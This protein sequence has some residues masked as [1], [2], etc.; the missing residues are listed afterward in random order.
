MKQPLVLRKFDIPLQSA[1][2][3]Y[4]NIEGRRGGII[5]FLLTVLN[6]NPVTSF[7]CYHNRIEFKRTSLSGEQLIIIPLTAVTAV[8]SGFTKPIGFLFAGIVFTYCQL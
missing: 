6:L 4:L 8:Q 7:K 5:S 1:D 2:G 3:L